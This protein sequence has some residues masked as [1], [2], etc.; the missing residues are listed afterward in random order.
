M[1]QRLVGL[2]ECKEGKIN[3]ELLQRDGLHSRQPQASDATPSTEWTE[4]PLDDLMTIT[5]ERRLSSNMNSSRTISH[6]ARH[7]SSAPD[8]ICPAQPESACPNR[9]PSIDEKSLSTNMSTSSLRKRLSQYSAPYL[10]SIMR[11]LRSYSISGSS[12]SS[13]RT[14]GP[15]KLSSDND[16]SIATALIFPDAFLRIDRHFQRQGLCIPGFK[17]HDSNSC[18]CA[19]A[20]ELKPK[21]QLWVCETGLMFDVAD[22]PNHL[23]GLDVQHRDQFGNTVLHLLA[24]RG[25]AFSAIVE[26]IDQGADANAK[27]TAGQNFLH[28]L[29]HTSLQ[30]L[31]GIPPV[32]LGVLEELYR[33]G[34][35]FHDRD[36]LGRSFFHL[37]SRHTN[38]LPQYSLFW[39]LLSANRPSR[40]AFGWAPVTCSVSQPKPGVVPAN[41]PTCQARPSLL[42]PDGSPGPTVG[43]NP[44]IPASTDA[45]TL[46][47]KHAR[48]LQTARLALDNLFIEDSEG[49]NGLQCLAEASLT[50]C[51]ETGKVSAR[52]SSRKRKRDESNATEPSVRLT[53][54]YELVQKMVFA[55]ANIN[56]YDLRGM[57]VLMSFVTYLPDGED[58]QIL[59][60]LFIYLIENGAN[61]NWRNRQGETA[62]HIA[63]R[64]GRKIAT[65]VLLEK[66]SNVHART[67]EGYGVIAEGRVHS[68]KVRDNPQLYASIM[69]C[70]ALAIQRGA[71]AR[72]TLVQEWTKI[73]AC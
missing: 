65:R 32:L 3:H 49:R 22:P 53:L 1:T 55:G 40:D 71:V 67:A 19:V 16:S 54:R 17:S 66:G 42:I 41:R 15:R 2:A 73:P 26:A 56:H 37:L 44:D 6:S 50:I 70:M 21:S 45:G 35:G 13:D 28:V 18:W 30:V 34:I 62:L 5:V 25:A 36:Y 31:A 60:K 11:L 20:E 51:A 52:G 29:H 47:L 27:N 46:I 33:F 23:K 7:S 64:L 59:E 12:V 72:P 48:L 8:Q 38:S 63:I 43:P 69:A 4:T 39:K 9:N 24:A 58:D 14:R 61:V 68:L 10:K 57:T